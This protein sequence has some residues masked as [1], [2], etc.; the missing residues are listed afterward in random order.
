MQFYNKL[1]LSV[2][3]SISSFLSFAQT[4]INN[5]VF[6]STFIKTKD[7]GSVI[8][9]GRHHAFSI[10]IPGKNVMDEKVGTASE[11]Q[12]YIHSDGAIIQTSW[13]PL[14]QPI[15]EKMQLSNLSIEEQKETLTGYVNYESD[16]L[17]N[18]LRTKPL[19]IKK[20]WVT[21]GTR[22]FLVWSFNFK[23]EKPD[24]GV[25]KQ[26]VKQI[27]FSTI[28][29]NQVLDLNMPVFEPN[30]FGPYKEMLKKISGTLKTYDKRLLLK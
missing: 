9:N 4:D 25:E 22:L 19:N 26:A 29:F 28:C 27:Y 14:P 2:F 30:K 11:N 17:E 16:Y 5:E 13:I 1:L 15:P 12:N 6:N 24:P 20:E 10:D 21:V 8:F 18:D 7:G 23:L 3:L